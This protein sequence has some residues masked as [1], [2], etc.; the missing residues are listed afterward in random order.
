M[1]S[2]AYGHLSYGTSICIR[3]FYDV[4]SFGRVKIHPMSSHD[5]TACVM[6]TLNHENSVHIKKHLI[7][8]VENMNKTTG[9]VTYKV[10]EQFPR[11]VGEQ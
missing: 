2:V 5:C 6:E 11:Y 3:T 8:D 4:E 9:P 7:I 1:S 10:E